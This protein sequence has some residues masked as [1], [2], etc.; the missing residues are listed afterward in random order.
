MDAISGRPGAFPDLEWRFNEFANLPAHALHVTC[1][2]IMALPATPT[3]VA[4][5]LVDTVLKG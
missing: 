4:Q 1:V 3:V 5:E 2:E